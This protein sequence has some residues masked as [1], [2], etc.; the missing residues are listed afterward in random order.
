MRRRLLMAALL[1]ISVFA[2]GT[3]AQ[4]QIQLYATIVDSTGAPA[5]SVAPS[6]VQVL[7]NDVEA[8][9]LKVE[10]IELTTKVQILIDNGSGVGSGNLA[11]L[12]NGVRGLIEAL[13]PGLE[14]TLVTTAPQPRFLIRATTDR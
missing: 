7:E 4:R 8:K 12:R 3:S 11:S 10:A 2:A 14:V 6:D 9:V 5:A 1:S 13:P